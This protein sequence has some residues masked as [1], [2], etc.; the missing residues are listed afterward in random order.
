MIDWLKAGGL[1]LAGLLPVLLFLDI[2]LGVQLA[3]D[4]GFFHCIWFGASL[5]F[6]GEMYKRAFA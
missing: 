2:A 1:T 4:Y 3:R 6:A 5:A